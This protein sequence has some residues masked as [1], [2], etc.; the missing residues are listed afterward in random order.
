MTMYFFPWLYLCVAVR[1]SLIC[2]CWTLPISLKWN[3]FSC[4]VWSSQGVL[5]F[6]L[7]IFYWENLYIH[8]SGK[9]FSIVFFSS[10]CW[11]H[12]NASFLQWVCLCSLISLFHSFVNIHVAV[13]KTG[14]VLTVS[15]C[16]PEFFFI[17]NLFLF[18][19]HCFLYMSLTCL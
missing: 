4:T 12:F 15:P 1:H 10:V 6:G 13:L 16:G 14:S 5:G 2:I 9:F 7:Q 17:G 18:Q 19:I 8:L 3:W 11:C